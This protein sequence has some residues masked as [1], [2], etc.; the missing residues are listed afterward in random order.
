MAPVRLLTRNVA[1]GLSFLY[2]AVAWSQ[3]ATSASSAPP[4]SRSACLAHMQLF[5][6]IQAFHLHLNGDCARQVREIL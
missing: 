2:T 5:T 4:G 3:A 6:D 1:M